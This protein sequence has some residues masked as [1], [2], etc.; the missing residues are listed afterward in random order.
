YEMRDWEQVALGYDSLVFDLNAT[1]LH[2]PVIWINTNTINYPNH[3]SFGLHSYVG[4]S[5]P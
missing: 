5:S 1:G 4:T 3:H 2:L